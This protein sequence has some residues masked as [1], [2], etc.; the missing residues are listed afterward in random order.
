MGCHFLL[1]CLKV[2]SES[3]V[4]QS[5]PTQRPHGL[6]PTRLLCPWDFPG[7]STREGCHCLLHLVIALCLKTKEELEVEPGKYYLK[8][9]GGDCGRL[10]LCLPQSFPS[11]PSYHSF[12]YE[13]V[14]RRH[15]STEAKR[16]F[17]ESM[18]GTS[19]NLRKSWW[20]KQD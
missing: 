16:E 20:E 18:L 4:A 13:L 6:Q 11:S 19:Q 12:H 17:A 3:E 14:G 15:Q 9:E 1:Q 5:C 2:K 7:K 8:Q 10:R